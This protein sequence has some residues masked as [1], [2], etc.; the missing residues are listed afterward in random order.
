MLW[1]Q[2]VYMQLRDRFGDL[3][4]WTQ[5][6]SS[7]QWG[8]YHLCC[9]QSSRRWLAQAPFCLLLLCVLQV[10]ADTARQ[11]AGHAKALVP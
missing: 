5:T 6:A 9:R 10:M 8:C 7:M 4:S 1:A 3:L 11:Q 2:Q